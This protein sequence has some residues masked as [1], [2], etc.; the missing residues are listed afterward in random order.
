MRLVIVACLTVSALAVSAPVASA[1]AVAAAWGTLTEAEALA[2]LM[3]SDPRVRALR[4]QIDEVRATQTQRTLWPNP[5]A[6]YSRESVSATRDVFLLARQE[7]PISGRIGRLR[8]AGRFAVDAVEASAAFQIT[9][10]QADLR[11]AFATLLAAQERE[12]VL[13][14][15]STDLRHLIEV[16][17]AREEAGEGSRYDRLRGER[18][19]VDLEADLA[20]TA[21]ARGRARA[22][23]A[24][25]LGPN[26]MPE[27]LLA[28]GTLARDAPPPPLASLIDRAL[29][30]RSD[31]RA[32]ELTVRQFEEEGRA[33]LALRTPTPTLAYGLKRSG[34]GELSQNGYQFSLDVA[35]PLFNRGQS[36]AA[37]ARAQAVRAAAETEFLRLRIEADVRA[38]HAALTLQQERDARYRQAVADAAEP[39]AA[40][41][42]V[43]Y[44]EGELG[45]LELLDASRQLLDARLRILDQTAATRRAAIELDRVTGLE[46]NP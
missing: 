26:V 1:Q 10:L 35:V 28:A 6:S 11:Q 22:E 2:R 17:R 39:L 42:R 21:V 8:E 36:A 3:A 16:L 40:I 23:L 19:L 24:T 7:L 20:A 41:A 38:S 31:F 34:T 18:A 37:L 30:S 46:M 5:V 4:A 14:Q 13:M 15:G 43:A 33:A 12:A 25:F 32:G 9:Q 29:A 44:E 45:I 27:S